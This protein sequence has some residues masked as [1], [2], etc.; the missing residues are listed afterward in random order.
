MLSDGFNLALSLVGRSVT[1]ER[2]GVMSPIS[3]KI[4]SSNFFRD[5]ATVEEVTVSGREF[6]ISFN[7]L[8]GTTYERLRKGDRLT[9]AL[10]GTLIIAE[11][12]EIFGTGDLL[13]YRI[14][15]N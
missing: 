1:L 7:D 2:P 3:I 14:R 6:V 4:A 13:G 15:T 10:M 12:R 11:I 8:R 9:D 5:F